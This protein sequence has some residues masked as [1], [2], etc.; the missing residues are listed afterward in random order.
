[1]RYEP[2]GLNPSATGCQT[3]TKALQRAIM[4]VYPELAGGATIYGCFNR[5]MARSARSWSLHAEGRALDVGVPTAAKELGWA[6][7]CELSI[8]RTIYG[9]QRVIWDGHIW[10]IE[11]VKGW[12]L[13]DKRTKDQHHDHTH[14]EQYWAAA[15]RPSSV[16][17]SYEKALQAARASSK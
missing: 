3:G 14:I 9:V 2:A 6:L 11:Q 17:Q 5:R 10:S 13:L 7:S 15:L 4:A 1:M 12:R 8:H 16:Q